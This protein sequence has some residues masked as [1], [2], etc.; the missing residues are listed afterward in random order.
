MFSR[1]ALVVG[2]ALLAVGLSGCV[3]PFSADVDTPSPRPL[4]VDG[5]ITSGPGP[6]SVT[7]S[8]AAA[9]ERSFE[10][11]SQRVS[12]AEVTIIDEDTGTQARLHETITGRYET[13]K[14][15]L[16]GVPGHAY[17]LEIIL[18][19]GREY[20]SVPQKMPEPVPLD[21]AFS[22]FDSSSGEQIKVFAVADDPEGT[23]NY[24]RWAVRVTREYPIDS[25]SP[26]FSCWEVGTPF[27]QIPILEDRLIDGGR[28]EEKVFGIR[29]GLKA[30]RLNQVD[31][32]QLTITE[33][34]YD[35]WSK[36]E[37]QVEDADDPFSAPPRP[38]RGNIVPVQDS[39]ERALGYFEVAGASPQSKLCFRQADFE[40]APPATPP[41]DGCPPADAIFESP[42]HWICTSSRN[43]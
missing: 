10:G 40:D 19:D 14:G 28:L 3:E 12:D 29:P 2:L 38:I 31:V 32:R 42:S 27:N 4:V 11:F 30:S 7:L 25:F 23:A 33:E 37:Q 20:R 6:H 39:V 9:F 18:S 35:F 5:S 1:S 17:R 36:V 26:P 24:Y 21:S 16:D 15:E 13:E 41:S 8:L 34:A 43:S 22:T